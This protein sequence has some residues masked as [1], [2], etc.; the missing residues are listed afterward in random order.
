[1]EIQYKHKMTS[2]IEE[3]IEEVMEKR[4][5]TFPFLVVVDTWPFVSERTDLDLRDACNGVIYITIDYKQYSQAQRDRVV[6]W[7]AS[8]L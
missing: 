6:T 3:M 1:M 5:S 7:L 2:Q 4:K 8:R